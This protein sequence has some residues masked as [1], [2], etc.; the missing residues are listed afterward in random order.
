M[1]MSKRAAEV[2]PAASPTSENEWLPEFTSVVKVIESATPKGI[3]KEGYYGIPM[4]KRPTW[5]W[6]IAWYFY[7][8]GISAGSFVIASLAKLTGQKRLQPLVRAG[9]YTSFV[10]F[11]PCPPLL[12]AD[13]GDPSRF[14]HMLR[15][16]KPTS[17]M[18]LGA[19]TL[20]VYSIPLALLAGAHAAA[21]LPRTRSLKLADDLRSARFLSALGIPPALVMLSYP[22]VLLST[23]ST[24]MWSESRLLGALFACS[25]F[26]AA[27]SAISIV[28]ALEGQHNHESLRRVESIE[29]VAR[30]AELIALGGYLVTSRKALKPLMKGRYGWEF[31]LGAIGAGVLLPALVKARAPRRRRS[32]LKTTILRSALSLAGGFVLKW[33]IT[34]AGRESAE[35]VRIAHNVTR[36]S[37]NAPGWG[38]AHHPT[39]ETRQVEL[40]VARP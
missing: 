21:E 1:V 22:G 9:Y 38:Q 31:W 18:N 35:D 12:I 32:S 11:L 15:V 37:R 34:H 29:R 7:L 3:A 33:A 14:H 36:P 26:A 2:V 8:E 6:E 27:A 13:L 23:T 16:F 28:L 30:I 17:P 25:S 20:S 39:S 4:L 40:D 19:W 24:P 10:S 5:G